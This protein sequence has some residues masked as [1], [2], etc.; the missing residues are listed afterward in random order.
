MMGNGNITILAG[1]FPKGFI[2]QKASCFFLAQFACFCFGSHIILSDDT[3]NTQCFAEFLRKGS[4]SVRF[5]PTKAMMDM[6]SSNIPFL[7]QTAENMQKGNIKTNGV[8]SSIFKLE[9]WEKAFDYATGK[10]GDF[11]VAFKFD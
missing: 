4:I 11:K 2:P 8:V 5:L 10:Y 9:D 3:G 6:D 7:F 1:N